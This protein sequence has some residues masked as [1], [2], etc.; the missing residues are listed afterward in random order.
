MLT[1]VRNRG[2]LAEGWYD[3]AALQKATNSGIRDIPPKRG[4][5]GK[6]VLPNYENVPRGESQDVESS[7]NDDLGPALP[8]HDGRSLIRGDRSG[9]AIPN[10][11]DLELQRGLFLFCH[12]LPT[13][14]TDPFICRAC[15]RRWRL[16][17]RS[18]PPPAHPKQKTRERK[19][20]RA[21]ASG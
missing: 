2:E 5:T 17:A 7:D 4:S 13:L 14:M 12:R 10:M 20:R 15:S 3:P 6:R 16:R 11:Q 21:C 9:P 1:F 19:T 18:S 8:N